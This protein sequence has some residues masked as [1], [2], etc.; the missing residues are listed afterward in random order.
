MDPGF[1][2]GDE[3]QHAIAFGKHYIEHDVLR[4]LEGENVDRPTAKPRN[5]EYSDKN[6]E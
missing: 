1:R 3:W 2:R 6:V 4:K 5:G